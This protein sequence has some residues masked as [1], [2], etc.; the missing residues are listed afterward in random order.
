M[1]AAFFYS[2]LNTFEETISHVYQNISCYSSF[3]QP[4]AG[5]LEK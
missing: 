1:Q 2:R 4:P 3:C 5:C